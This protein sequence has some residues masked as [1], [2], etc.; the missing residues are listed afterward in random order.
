M[1][2]LYGPEPTPFTL[3]LV[4]DGRRHLV[5][6]RK[7]PLACPVRILHGM[8]DPDVPWQTSLKLCQMLESEDVEIQF[9]KAGDHRLSQPH[10]LDRLGRT[11]ETLL[12]S[13]K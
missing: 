13:L 11:L 1:H 4:E 8:R 6:R 3:A 10:D 2:S 12:D 9:V 7:M 5:L